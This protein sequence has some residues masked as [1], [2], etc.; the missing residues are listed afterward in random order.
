MS[1]SESPDDDDDGGKLWRRP[2]P[3][4]HDREATELEVTSSDTQTAATMMQIDEE[5]EEEEGKGIDNCNAAPSTVA[6]HRKDMCKTSTTL[7]SLHGVQFLSEAMQ[8]WF[9]QAYGCVCE[10]CV[11]SCEIE[12]SNSYIVFAYLRSAVW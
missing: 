5:E 11:Y 12:L 9:I 7:T 8:S 10:L 1:S 2:P 4:P 6:I 3:F